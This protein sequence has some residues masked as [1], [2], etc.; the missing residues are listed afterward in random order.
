MRGR[1][2]APPENGTGDHGPHP[3]ERRARRGRRPARGSAAGTLLYYAQR[4]TPPFDR[5]QWIGYGLLALGAGFAGAVAVRWARGRT[6]G[7]LALL[8]LATGLGAVAVGYLM[9]MGPGS[10]ALDGIRSAVA[11]AMLVLVIVRR[12][13]AGRTGRRE[14]PAG[15][16]VQGREGGPPEPA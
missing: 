15:S 12:W 2:P 6:P 13:A 7:T 16:G 14:P 4:G 3:P 1:S 11:G 9:V 8:D 10:P 5:W